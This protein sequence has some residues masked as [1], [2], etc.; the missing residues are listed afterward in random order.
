MRTR[1]GGRIIDVRRGSAAAERIGELPPT[2]DQII[3]AMAA[4][5]CR[6]DSAESFVR[7]QVWER[8]R[9]AG[10]DPERLRTL[11]SEALEAYRKI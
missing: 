10:N 3:A 1:D 9:G 8:W 2:R 4:C 5:G 7:L 11:V 6:D